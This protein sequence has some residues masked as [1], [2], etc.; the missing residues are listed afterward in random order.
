MTVES[1]FSRTT[2]SRSN[3]PESFCVCPNIGDLTK[4]WRV[5]CLFDRHLTILIRVL[6]FQPGRT[7]MPTRVSSRVV[8]S[9]LA[10]NI[11]KGFFHENMYLL[12]ICVAWAI[13]SPVKNW[14]DLNR[15][16]ITDKRWIARYK[17]D[18]E[19]YLVRSHAGTYCTKHTYAYI[20]YD[21]NI[22]LYIHMY[23]DGEESAQAID[24]CLP[25]VVAYIRIRVQK[26]LDMYKWQS[27]GIVLL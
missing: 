19:L 18:F 21:I 1:I 24:K 6:K 8:I 17:W 11:F 5:H 13:L 4:F 7:W 15:S 23:H 25:I 12:A 16:Q 9:K 3:F 14:R 20:F 2:R 27:I 22:S 26:K 10:K